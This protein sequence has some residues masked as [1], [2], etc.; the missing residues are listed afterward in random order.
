MIIGR[1]RGIF[2]FLL[3]KGWLALPFFSLLIVFGCIAFVRFGSKYR[4][5]RNVKVRNVAKSRRIKLR[6]KEINSL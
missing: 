1:R 5:L 3:L 2:M 4:G 6:L